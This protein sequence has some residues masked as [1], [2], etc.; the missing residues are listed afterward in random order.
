MNIVLDFCICI[1][2]PCKNTKFIILEPFS[3]AQK[4]AKYYPYP[5]KKTI[6]NLMNF[7]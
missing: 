7:G 5:Y 4:K 2:K 6:K 1:L 3:V